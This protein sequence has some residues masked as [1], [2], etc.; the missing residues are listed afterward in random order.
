MKYQGTDPGNLE[1][2]PEFHQ[3]F[4]RICEHH[5]VAILV[6]DIFSGVQQP[7]YV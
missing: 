5:A 7:R 6:Q 3:N 2:P 1:S 4:P